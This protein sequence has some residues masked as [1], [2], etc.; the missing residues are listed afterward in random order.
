MMHVEKDE[1]SGFPVADDAYPQLKAF[2][3]AGAH[4]FHNFSVEQVREMY[5][6]SCEAAPLHEEREP[7]QT[8]FELEG[9]TVRLYDPRPESEHGQVGPAILFLHGGGWIMGNLRTHH[10]AARRIATRTGFP[11]LAVD[12]RLAPE[13]PYPAAIDDSR[14]ALRWFLDGKNAHGM[15]VSSIS[16]IGDSAGGQ[17][18]AVLANEFAG[19]DIVLDS[20]V[21][22]YPVTDLTE[23]NINSSESY[24][25][26]TEGFP[27]VAD[28]MVWFADNYVERGSI[29]RNAD[30]SP[31]Y[32]DLPER[33]PAT[34]IITLDNDPLAAEGTRYAEKLRASGVKVVHDHLEGYAHGLFTSAGRIPTGESYLNKA[35]DFISTHAQVVSSTQ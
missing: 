33:L 12:Y 27:L 17:L 6:S 16:L 20:Q 11:V 13:H 2:R 24:Q 7:A 4:S 15:Q 25:R 5:V 18:A 3:D 10:Y 34:Y 22:I 31:Q 21:L 19:N 23:E 8:D 35:A 9:Y 29:R 26:I 28:T 1:F 30:L 32:A 14:A